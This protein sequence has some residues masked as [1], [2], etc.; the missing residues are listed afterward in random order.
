MIKRKYLPSERQSTPLV[1]A[2][3]CRLFLT[4]LSPGGACVIVVLVLRISII[5]IDA[6]I[7]FLILFYVSNILV[8][9]LL[10]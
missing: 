4:D 1:G 10:I 6:F 7:E 5:S 8:F 9:V 2:Q 3:F